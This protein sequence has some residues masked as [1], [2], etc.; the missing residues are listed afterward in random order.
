MG[1]EYFVDCFIWIC[2]ILRDI[3][4]CIPFGFCHRISFSFLILL[5]FGDI[6]TPN[7]IV[8]SILELGNF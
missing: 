2:Y 6:I 3:P 8:I 7:Q 4:L 5:S 1:F